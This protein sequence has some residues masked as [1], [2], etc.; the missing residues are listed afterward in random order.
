MF[1]KTIVAFFLGAFLSYSQPPWNIFLSLF[2]IFPILLILLEKEISQDNFA[3]R[4]LKLSYYG[5]LFL[6]SYFL[7]GFSWISSAFE[8]RIGFDD[9][10]NYIVFERQNY[11]K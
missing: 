3:K 1:V 4:F 10:Q 7:F 8:Y 2:F 9:F 5:G 11:R 6:Y